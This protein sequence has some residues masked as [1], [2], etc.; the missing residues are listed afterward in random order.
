MHRALAI[1]EFDL[2]TEARDTGRSRSQTGIVGSL[3]LRLTGSVPPKAP[4]VLG[5]LAR[6]AEFC[7]TGAQTTHGYGATTTAAG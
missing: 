5:T 6:F 2:H 1:S 7:G 3:T 4:G